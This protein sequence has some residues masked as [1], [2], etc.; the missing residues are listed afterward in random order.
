MPG[1]RIT[2]NRPE[3]R[4]DNGM[5]ILW[6]QLA[7]N[8]S[9]MALVQVIDERGVNLQ[10]QAFH[11][12][13]G[14]MFFLCLRTHGENMVDLEGGDKMGSSRQSLT[15]NASEINQHANVS[16]WYVGQGC[17]HKNEQQNQTNTNQ[18]RCAGNRSWICVDDPG[19]KVCHKVSP[20]LHC[21]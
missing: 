6:S 7:V 14:S 8:I 2:N 5:G 10:V 12:W 18:N 17:P 11:G 3:V 1:G 13:C 20:S 4:L 16:R 21:S 9:R 19:I 15:C